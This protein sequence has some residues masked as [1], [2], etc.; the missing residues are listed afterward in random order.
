MR[1]LIVTALL[2]LV[3][4]SA[5]SAG[6]TPTGGGSI[7]D[8]MKA[9]GLSEADVNAALKTY[10]PTGKHDD[11]YVFASGGH[12]GQVVVIGVP[13]MRILKYI[14]VFTPEPCQGYGYGDDGTGA[15]MKQGRRHGR[16][17]TWADTHHPALS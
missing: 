8:L 13:S 2:A 16:D 10:T 5:R 17:I 12:S 3:A 11:H 1:R 14:S 7:S 9:R 15:I 6:V 4:C